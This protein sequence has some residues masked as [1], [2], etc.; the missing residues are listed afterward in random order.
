MSI[1]SRWIATRKKRREKLAAAAAAARKAQEA[2]DAAQ[3]VIDRHP[4]PRATALNFAKAQLGVK[5]SPANSNRG[6]KIDEWQQAVGMLAQPWC[7]AFVAAC[8]RKAGVKVTDRM[9]YCPYIVED[10]KAGRNGLVKVVPWSQRQTGDL[11]VYQW[12]S[13]AVDHVGI[14]TGRD[15]NGLALVI[16]GNTAVGNDSNGGQVMERERDRK[17]VA[18]VCRPRWP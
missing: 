9:R 5:E 16:E 14:Y 13:G 6:P 12:D 17:F 4:G 11:F 7:G 15:S 10:A 8:L 2:Y 18:A 3:R 1:R